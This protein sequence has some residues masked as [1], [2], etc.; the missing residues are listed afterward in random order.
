MPQMAPYSWSLYFSLIVMF[1]MFMSIMNY[2]SIM[3]NMK[4][5]NKPNQ[6]KIK[7]N[8]WKW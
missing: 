8:N 1:L 3:K 5:M 4:N 2:F 6:M 7:L